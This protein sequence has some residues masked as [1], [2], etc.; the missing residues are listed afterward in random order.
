MKRR[1]PL[2][3]LL[4]WSATL[5]GIVWAL[6]LT[7]CGIALALPIALM[8]GGRIYVV[9]EPTPALLVRGPFAD[10][11]LARHP[12]GAMSAMAIGHVVIA[13]QHGLTKQILT[14]ELAHVQQAARWGVLFPFAYLASSAWVAL[15]GQD[16]YW[17]NIFEIAARNAEKHV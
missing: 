16:A 10:Y 3:C 9:Q 6:P 11:L 13:E 14:H 1:K 15:R 7:L 4:R 17:H 5:L 8:R 2:P 12:F